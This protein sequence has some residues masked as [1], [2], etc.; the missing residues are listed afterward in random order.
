MSR[1]L[2]SV[3]WAGPL[4]AAK[5]TPVGE[6]IAAPITPGSGGTESSP[7]APCAQLVSIQSPTT[8]TPHLSQR[9]LRVKTV[10]D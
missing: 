8:Q 7:I 10:V 4:S 1:A 5:S 6:F 9:F 2:V 3:V